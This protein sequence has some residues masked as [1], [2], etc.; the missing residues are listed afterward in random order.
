VSREKLLDIS[1]RSRK[2]QMALADK[3]GLHEYAQPAGGC[4]FLTNE[5][6]S[7]KLADLW[8]ARG[9]KE[10][11]LDDIMLLKVG[12]HL[13]PR[14]H[15]KLIV[16]RDEGENNFLQGYRRR[17]THLDAVSHTGPLVLLDG[18][19][20]DDDIV[21]A[22]RLTA[23]FGHGRDAESVDVQV[24]DTAGKSRVVNVPPMPA[25]EIPQEWYI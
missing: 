21:L 3:F 10:Y 11:E 5:Q 1:G 17:F 19:A 15:F 20:G 14:P 12:R 18:S 22:A 13:R 8:Q 25:D 16:G 2:P 6:Y 24:T 4:C 7:H 23:R 9:T